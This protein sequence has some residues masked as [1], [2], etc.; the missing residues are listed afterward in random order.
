MHEHMIY[1]LNMLLVIALPLSAFLG[2]PTRFEAEHK[3]TSVYGTE[4]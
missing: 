4:V 2:G 1:Q 3:I